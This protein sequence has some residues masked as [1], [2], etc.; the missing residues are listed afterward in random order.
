[1][2]NQTVNG[3]RVFGLSCVAALLVLA[4]CSSGGGSSDDDEGPSENAGPGEAVASDGDGVKLT[5]ACGVAVEDQLFNPVAT[6][7]GEPVIVKTVVDSNLVVVTVD[8]QD[9]L[10]KLHGLGGTLGFDNTAAKGLITNLTAAPVHLFTP[11]ECTATV[12]GGEATV[13]Q[14]VNESGKSFSEEIVKSGFAGEIESG[15]ACG[16]SQIT[17]CLASL[18]PGAS[19]S[20]EGEGA[21]A[22]QV[23]EFL[24]KP[25]SESPYNPGGLSILTDPCGVRVFVNGE[26][27]R[28]YGPS[29]ER[30]HTFRSAKSGCSYG[31]ATVSVVDAATGEPV[32]FGTSPTLSVPNGCD[33]VE[34]A[35]IA[36]GGESGGGESVACTTAPPTFQYSPSHAPCGGNAAV[37]LS[38]EFQ[39]A[40]SVQ[41][42][43][44][45]G[46]D[47]LD[48]SCADASCSPYKS[49]QY[50]NGDTTKT[51]CFGAPGTSVVMK[52]VVHSSIK[53]AGDDSDPD[54]FCI[55]N[56]AAAVN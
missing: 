19:S 33:R 15:N 36:N 52:A 13:G 5:T 50:I 7:D 29:N 51:A 23:G 38:G 27:L 22:R 37:I 30:C 11:G 32:Y 6:G 53:M 54:R 4:G 42:R 34:F 31:A 44:S 45:D 46:S 2:T 40:F 8:G 17:G 12:E 10:V 14:L 25:D 18:A 21:P 41:L 24:W 1:M 47:R 20:G 16:E 43:K 49:Q 28:D 3:Y 55:P 39:D 48:P 56:P 26:E 9:K 35:G